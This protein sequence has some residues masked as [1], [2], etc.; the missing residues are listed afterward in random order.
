MARHGL[1]LTLTFAIDAAMSSWRRSC[2]STVPT[3]PRRGHACARGPDRSPGAGDDPPGC[4]ARFLAAQVE[5]RLADGEDHF[6]LDAVHHARRRGVPGH[7]G[8]YDAD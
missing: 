4:P 1:A 5:Q 8:W 7:D 3:V 6:A 2:R